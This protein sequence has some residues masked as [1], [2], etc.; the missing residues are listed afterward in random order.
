MTQPTQIR[1]VVRQALDRGFL[2]LEAE[3][4]LRQLLAHRYSQ[5][6]WQAFMLLQHA[7][8]IGKVQQESR[9]ILSH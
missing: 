4:I 6:D 5:E 9:L 2:D 1:D 7:A 8:M 3:N